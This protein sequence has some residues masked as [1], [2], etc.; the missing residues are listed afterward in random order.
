MTTNALEVIEVCAGAK[1]WL[2]G[3][4]FAANDGFYAEIHEQKDGRIRRVARS[5]SLPS[6][7]VAAAW[8]RSREVFR[9][10]AA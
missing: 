8:M 2:F 9:N 1:H 6:R 10:H 3:G 4:V 7:E 5:E